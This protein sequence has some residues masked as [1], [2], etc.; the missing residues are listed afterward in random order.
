MRFWVG[1]SIIFILSTSVF[2]EDVSRP[3]VVLRPCGGTRVALTD[4]IC[5]PGDIYDTEGAYY[6]DG[7]GIYGYLYPKLQ[8]V[9]APA[10]HSHAA[11]TTTTDG[12]YSASDK[13]RIE[14]WLLSGAP[15]TKSEGATCSGA[16]TSLQ[17][18]GYSLSTAKA[19]WSCIA[20]QVTDITAIGTDWAAFANAA[21]KSSVVVVSACS[22]MFERPATVAAGTTVAGEGNLSIISP[23]EDIFPTA[24]A[25]IEVAGTGQYMTYT[26]GNKVVV[27]NLALMETDKVT[28]GPIGGAGSYGV[29]TG[30]KMAPQTGLD[31]TDVQFLHLNKGVVMPDLG[32][33][34][35]YQHNYTYRTLRPVYI[36]GSVGNVKVKHST[37]NTTYKASSSNE[38]VVT[39]A[40]NIGIDDFEFVDNAIYWLKGFVDYTNTT[41]MPNFVKVA[42]NRGYFYRGQ[43][44]MFN[45]VMA[46][47]EMDVSRNFLWNYSASGA[48]LINIGG[49]VA[50]VRDN[51]TG[52]DGGS[53]YC[54]VKVNNADA[55]VQFSGNTYGYQYGICA[56]DNI[57]V[58]VNISG[59]NHSGSTIRRSQFAYPYKV[60]LLGD[61]RKTLT[62]SAATTIV[63]DMDE[64]QIYI[65]GTGTVNLPAVGFSQIM[66]YN[67]RYRIT[68]A[69]ANA[70]TIG[71]GP[72][73]NTRIID[74]FGTV[75]YTIDI[76]A[77]S[78]KEFSFVSN[79]YR[80]W[81][82]VIP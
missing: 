60:T 6:I 25:L 28:T 36:A 69:T 74:R 75:M 66:S 20:N 67:G 44:I 45:V 30:I 13:S 42:D 37:F 22:H 46:Q 15:S 19:K 1:C 43:P 55:V 72:E 34:L 9:L 73:G 24:N 4:N 68:N 51:V 27:K 76:P 17:A 63:P 38:A 50:T 65:T 70:K 26:P 33:R 54:F 3:T 12:F 14:A 35:N 64:Y 8:N 11:A 80:N 59:D 5:V 58:T 39:T 53:A 41:A 2:A 47:Y 71:I 78:S 52:H 82:E 10:T 62:H 79:D 23:K 16:W 56:S 18:A 77:F 32:E 48:P 81:V 7:E 49:G 21:C 57:Q 40:A 61:Y 31:V 29:F